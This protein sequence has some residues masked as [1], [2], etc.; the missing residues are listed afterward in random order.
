MDIDV[1]NY[2]IQQ[3]TKK[4]L[5]SITNLKNQR[6]IVS[7]KPLNIIFTSDDEFHKSQMP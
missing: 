3:M 2:N 5:K 4:N 1:N 7:I 6:N